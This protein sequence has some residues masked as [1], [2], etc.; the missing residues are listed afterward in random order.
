MDDVFRNKPDWVSREISET[1]SRCL[2]KT[3]EE[4]GSVRGLE[5][6][7]A[8][9]FS[10]SVIYAQLYKNNSDDAVLRCFDLSER[11]YY[12]PEYQTGQALWEIHGPDANVHYT[13][14]VTS[15]DIS[16]VEELR[17]GYDFLFIDANH[18]SPWPAFDLLSLSRFLRE[19]AI[20]GLDDINMCYNKKFRDC[21]GAQCMYRAWFGEKW[22]FRGASNVGILVLEDM[23]MVL[24]SVLAAISVDW[25]MKVKD[26][27]LEKYLGIVE[28]I[29]SSRVPQFEKI[30]RNKKM[31]RRS[32]K[33]YGAL[34]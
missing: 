23:G 3:L 16:E 22:R 4:Y 21:N 24:D 15:A 9:G 13:Y 32:L 18:R 33:D 30:I 20:I 5:I 14:G 1:E 34:A 10:G 17:D 12:D 25:D 11:C 26:E 29:D 31:L 8:S 28:E 6:G 7:S 2:A 19:G 27:T